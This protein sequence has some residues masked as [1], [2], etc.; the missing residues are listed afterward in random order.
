MP[1]KRSPDTDEENIEDDGINSDRRSVLDKTSSLG[2]SMR[3]SLQNLTEESCIDHASSR[4]LRQGENPV[5]R[6]SMA[7]E[8]KD[9]RL[10]VGSSFFFHLGNAAILPLLSQVIALDSGRAG[11]PFTCGNV[12]IAQ[13][14][15][16]F[17]TV[18]MGKSI[19][20]GH[21][22]KVSVIAGYIIGVPLRCA[23]ILVL[24]KYQ[25]NPYALMATQVLDGVGA[26]TFGLSVPIY[27]K[28]L[29]AGTFVFKVGI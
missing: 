11:I 9:L 10:Y 12:G 18:A 16:I 27:L 1:L 17:A 2:R 4:N 23:V 6:L 8:N 15:S 14:S 5:S 26:G 20:S 24:I 19:S 25:Q 3:R 13:L 21:G 7:L 28:H 29:T 22:Y